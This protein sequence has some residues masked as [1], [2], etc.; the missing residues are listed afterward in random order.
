MQI[1]RARMEKVIAEGGSVMFDD[2]RI[3]TRVSDLPSQAILAK[4]NAEATS[5]VQQQLRAE[6]D[7]IDRELETLQP[8]SPP[9]GS[10]V[11]DA[12]GLSPNA[13]DK[14]PD[15]FP[16]KEHLDNDGRFVTI[17]QVAAATDEDLISVKFIGVG[18][19]ADIR[20][21]LAEKK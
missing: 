12:K 9:A 2:G 7:R 17:S 16:G 15:G 13:D 5:A 18:T 14:L 8:D 19:L 20:T 10:A 21:F 6:R 1:S 4:G 11:A 3:V